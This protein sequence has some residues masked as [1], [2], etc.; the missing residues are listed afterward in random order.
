MAN[1]AGKIK[2]FPFF[3]NIRNAF[4]GTLSSH[5][6]R[7]SLMYSVVALHISF[8]K[9]KEKRECQKIKLKASHTHKYHDMHFAPMHA[10][11]NE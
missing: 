11:R 3:L 5:A 1:V 2:M 4:A 8:K 9:L 7:H 6:M 10:M